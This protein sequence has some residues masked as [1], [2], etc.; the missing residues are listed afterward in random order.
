MKNFIFVVLISATCS[1]D[2]MQE[3]K[4][5]APSLEVIKEEQ[6]VNQETHEQ[7][8]QIIIK[9]MLAQHKIKPSNNHEVSKLGATFS[10]I[11][12]KPYRPSSRT[13]I[14][15]LMSGIDDTPVSPTG[16]AADSMATESMNATK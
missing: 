6:S 2:G 7:Q 8:E 13:R 12:H 10:K 1:V 15:D 16:V 9:A 3:N 4:K 14:N 11:R 5:D